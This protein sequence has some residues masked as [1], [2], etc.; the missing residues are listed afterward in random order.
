MKIKEHSLKVAILR[1]KIYHL[2]GETKQPLSQLI[3]IT[4][5]ILTLSLMSM[6]QFAMIYVVYF[7]DYSPMSLYSSDFNLVLSYE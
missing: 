3:P 4:F 2:L 1:L 5:F 7:M 6:N